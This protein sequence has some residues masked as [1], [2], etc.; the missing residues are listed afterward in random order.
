MKKTWSA[1]KGVASTS[2]ESWLGIGTQNP[3]L[4]GVALTA[5]VLSLRWTKTTGIESLIPSIK[6]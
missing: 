1:A 4:A 5:F 6:K 2:Y 3:I